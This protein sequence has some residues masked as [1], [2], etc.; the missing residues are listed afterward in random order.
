MPEPVSGQ[1]ERALDELEKIVARLEREDLTLDESVELFKKGRELATRCEQLLAQA[2]KTIDLAMKD[3]PEK[4][5][6]RGATNE[7]SLF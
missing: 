2:Q 3:E 1:F 4:T 6:L 5:P 7:E